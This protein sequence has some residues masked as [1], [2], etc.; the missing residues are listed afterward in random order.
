MGITL[1]SL[2]LEKR[3]LYPRD[4]VRVSLRSLVASGHCAQLAGLGGVIEW[5]ELNRV[6]GRVSKSEIAE[7]D[8]LAAVMFV[9]P[10]K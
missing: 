9:M 6:G 8:F 7:G 10:G 2:A 4:V 1:S 5:G 3:D